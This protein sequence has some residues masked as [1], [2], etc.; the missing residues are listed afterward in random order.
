MEVFSISQPIYETVV[1]ARPSR[2]IRSPYLADIVSPTGNVGATVLAHTP[3]LGGCGLI[4]AGSTVI[5]SEKPITSSAKSRFTIDM[6]ILSEKRHRIL[7]GINPNYANPIMSSILRLGLIEQLRGITDIRSEVCVRNRRLD[8]VGHRLGRTVYIEVKNVPL[9]DYCDCK[10]RDRKKMNFE[11]TPFDQKL[12]IF[13]DGYRKN[14]TAPVSPRAVG[15]VDL[16]GSLAVRD[17][18]EAY[19]VFVAQR[20]DVRAFTPSVLDPT[21]RDALQKALDRGMR[22]VACQVEWIGHKAYFRRELP[23]IF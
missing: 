17:N 18:A 11:S 19:L 16:L 6:V 20:P 7:V 15:H 14:A 5:V 23:V 12:A 10:S 9:A 2:A 22:I 4:V 21:Y 13:P 3:A 1:L 8:F